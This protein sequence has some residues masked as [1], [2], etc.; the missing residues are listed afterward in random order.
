[1]LRY[2]KPG[3][4]VRRQRKATNAFA[5]ESAYASPSLLPG[6]PNDQAH[7]SQEGAD[8]PASPSG[9]LYRAMQPS[10]VILWPASHSVQPTTDNQSCERCAPVCPIT[11]VSYI[12]FITTFL[13]QNGGGTKRPAFKN[14]QSRP[15]LLPSNHLHHSVTHRSF[16]HASPHLWNQ[17]PTSFRI[18][19]PNYSSPSQR[20]SFE[21]AGLTC[22]TLLP[23]SITFH[24]FTLS[25]KLTFSENLVLH[26]SLFLSVGL[27][28]RL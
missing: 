27:L 16:R 17:L 20:P 1:M 12:V 3:S 13:P 19:H 18:P 8:R 6:R 7:C 28:S 5:V 15:T 4:V 26:N 22:Y 24:C 14:P 10:R 11:R 9:Y 23:P 2:V 25:L 21:H